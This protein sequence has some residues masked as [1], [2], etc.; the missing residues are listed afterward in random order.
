MQLLVTPYSA[1]RAIPHSVRLSVL[2][3]VGA[4]AIDFLILLLLAKLLPYPVG[5]LTGFVYSVLGDALHFGP[6][7][8]QSVGKRILKLQVRRVQPPEG[9]ARPEM[10]IQNVAMRNLPVGVAT[11]F[12]IIPVWG[13][14]LLPLV[15]L[16]LMAFEIWLMIRIPGGHRFGDV[17][18]DTEVI[19]LEP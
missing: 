10:G 2:K 11:F 15:G 6:F 9:G 8:Y 16:P 18:G 3:R 13:W 17:L 4:R 12:L 19:S 7:K 1:L 5:V 14:I